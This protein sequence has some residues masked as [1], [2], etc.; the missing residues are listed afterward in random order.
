MATAKFRLRRLYSFHSLAFVL[1][2]S[3]AGITGAAIGCANQ[4]NASRDQLWREGNGK[5]VAEVKDLDPR[6][7]LSPLVKHIAP[8][9][10]SIR[11]TGKMQQHPM[12]RDGL[13]DWLPFNMPNVPRQGVGSGFILS[14]DGLVVTNHH[15]VRDSD[16]FTVK[17]ADDRLFSA[18]LVG[19]DPYTDIALLQLENA[20]N[21]PTVVLGASE[22]LSMGDW[23]LAMGAPMGLDQTATTGII[24]AKGRGSLGLY[25]NSY[26]DFLQTDAA[27]SPGNSGGPLFNL[28]GEVVGINTAIGMGQGI[29]FAIPI[30]QAKKVIP[31][32]K[33]TGKVVRG[34]LGISGQEIEPVVGQLPQKGAVVGQ[35]YANTPAG[36]A[37]LQSGDRI[38]TVDQQAIENFSDLRGRIAEQKPGE[39]VRFKVERGKKVVNID[40]IL[41]ALPEEGELKRIGQRMVQPETDLYGSAK[42]SLGVEVEEKGGTLTVRSVK[43]GSLAEDLGLRPGDQLESINGEAIRTTQDVAQAL[44]KDR[45]RVNVRVKRGNSTHSATFERR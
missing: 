9:V 44:N 6:Q 23:V 35:V 8:T 26:I 42:P 37:G 24:S 38:L 27:I 40:V 30:D 36:K 32:L 11:T 31:Q 2:L 12:Q 7:S 45:Q 28:K 15:V 29:G 19:S 41:G 39:K 14:A 34:W 13:P 5:P 1:A 43:P 3:G 17:L 4:A 10:V 20:A 22:Q 16:E 25:S 18:K 33:T 21:L